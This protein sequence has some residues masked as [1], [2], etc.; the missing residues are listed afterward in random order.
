[1][2]S[3]GRNCK[4]QRAWPKAAHKMLGNLEVIV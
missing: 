1:M 2:P 4:L 3:E